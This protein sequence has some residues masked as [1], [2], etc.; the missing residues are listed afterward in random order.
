MTAPPRWLFGVVLACACVTLLR[1][2]AAA[3]SLRAL[4]LKDDDKGCTITATPVAFGN[5]DVTN[6]SPLSAFGSIT[7]SCGTHTPGQRQTPI[8]DVRIELSRGSSVSFDRAMRNG[9]DHLRYNLFL[10]AAATRVWGDGSQGTVVYSMSN[11]QNHQSYTV[12]IFGRVFEL[13]DVPAGL[14]QDSITATI[15]F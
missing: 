8:K 5:Y 4:A 2:T 14:Y 10:D 1:P 6:P 7:Y 9:A 3:Q 13:Q 11:L 15:L 12:T